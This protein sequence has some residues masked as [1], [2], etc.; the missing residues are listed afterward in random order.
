MPDLFTTP[1]AHRQGWRD[2]ARDFRE[3]HPEVNPG[4]V[5]FIRSGDGP[6]KIGYSKNVQR[7]LKDLQTI[8]PYPLSILATY[9][10]CPS[11]ERRFHRLFAEHRL[12]GEWFAPHE[13]ILAEIEAVKCR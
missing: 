10:G 4:F 12:E 3:R 6:I 9:P 8:S 11:D 2:F 7:R 1:E 13:D 5:Y